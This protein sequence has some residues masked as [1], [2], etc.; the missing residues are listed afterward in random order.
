ML[1]HGG[2]EMPSYLFY[3]KETNEYFEVV[4]KISEYNQF[5]EENIDRYERVIEAPSLVSGTASNTKVPDGFKEVLS[6]ISEAHP[7]SELAS[8]HRRR[9]IKEAKTDDIVNRHIKRVNERL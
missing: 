8:R 3:D 9:S 4:M 2:S 7:S 6:K 1:H 5:K